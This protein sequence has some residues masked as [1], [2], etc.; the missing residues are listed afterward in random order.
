MRLIVRFESVHISISSAVRQNG[1]HSTARNEAPKPP[2]P[3]TVEAGARNDGEPS[4]RTSLA[5]T[6]GRSTSNF[7][8]G[9]LADKVRFVQI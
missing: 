8:I 5:V 4:V 1:S 9:D 2:T 3:S 7:W 6:S